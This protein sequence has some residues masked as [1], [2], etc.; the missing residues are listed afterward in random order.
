MLLRGVRPT[1]IFMWL[2]ARQASICRV[3]LFHLERIA[4]QS[5]RTWTARCI[6]RSLHCDTCNALYPAGWWRLRP[7]SISRPAATGP[8]VHPS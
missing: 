7:L 1:P 4:A 3:G 2:T 8:L 5:P 6:G